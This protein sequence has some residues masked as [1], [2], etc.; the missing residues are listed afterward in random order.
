MDKKVLLLSHSK[1]YYLFYKR[2]P[3]G[4][5]INPV[6]SLLT[7]WCRIFFEKLISH[8]D[9]Q[10]IPCFLHGTRM[11]ITVLTKA[12]HWIVSWARRIQF[13]PSIPISL[14]S[15]LML[16]SHLRLCLPQR[17]LTFG[18]PN[19]NPINTSPL[20]PARHMSSPPHPV[21]SLRHCFSKTHFNIILTFTL[22]SPKWLL[23]FGISD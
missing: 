11:F 7:L 12:R 14:S 18:P 19:Q 10:T 5:V 1:D 2:S 20:P 4:T 22:S 3:F 21:L 17:F 15:I 9:C 6:L 23:G 16:S 8:S 13:A